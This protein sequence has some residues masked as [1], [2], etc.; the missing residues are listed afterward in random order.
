M[1]DTIANYTGNGT[2]TD[3]VVP[4]DYLKKSFVHVYV[5]N[6]LT[7]LTGGDYGDT[8]ADYYFLD[9]TTIRLK[10]AP[11]E[12][13][14]I[15]VRRYTS[16]TE[17]IVSFED[18]SI[19]KAT[20]LDTSQLQ[21][22]HIA[23]EAR[24]NVKDAML[25]DDEGNWDAQN[26]RIVNVADPV[27]DQDAMTLG[28]YKKDKQSVIDLK[29]ETKGY[30]DEALGFRNEAEEFKDTTKGYKD[31]TEESKNLAK[32]WAV[33]M[34]GKVVE[35]GEEIDYSA[36]YWAQ[37]VAEMGEAAKVVADNIDDVNTVA[38]N[39]DDINTV[40]GDL[41]GTFMPPQFTDMGR[42]GTGETEE[43]EVTG[44]NIKTVAD[45][46]ED[47]NSVASAIEDGSL[48][49]AIDSIPVTVENVRL[50]NEAKDDA[51]EASNKAKDW[52]IKIDGKVTDDAGLEVDYSSKYYANQAKAS[53]E[54][55]NVSADVVT[56][57]VTDGVSQINALSQQKVTEI[58]NAGT[59]QVNNVNT[60]GTAQVEAVNTAGSTQVSAVEDEG[61]SQV[62]AVTAEGTK[63]TGLVTAEG[64]KQITLVE[65]KGDS[66]IA[67]MDSSKDGLIAEI[68]TEG[69]T[70]LGLIE[71]AGTTQVGNINTAGTTQVS[72]VN[73]AGDTQVQAVNTAGTTQLAAIG[74]SAEEAIADIEPYVQK[75]H[76]WADK[77]DG[78]VEG[79]AYS[80]KYWANQAASGQLNA[81]WKETDSSN[82]GY[83][84]NKPDL[85]VYAEKTYVD[86]ALSS[87]LVYKGSVNTYADLPVASQKVGDMYNVAQADSSHGIK[88]GDNVAWNGSAWDVL[89][90]TV[91]L[92]AYLTKS[93]ASS[94]YATIDDLDA[95]NNSIDTLET[96]VGTK[97]NDSAV[98][99]LTG[100]Q[101]ITGTKTFS[102][103]IAGN[104]NGT[105]RNV[106]ERYTKTTRGDIEYGENNNYLIDKAALALWNGRYSGTSSNLEYC[107]YGTI[108]DTTRDQT[109]G[110]TKTFS[111]TIVGSINGNAATADKLKTARTINGTSFNGSA[112]ININNIVS[113]GQVTG[114]TGSTRGSVKG[115]QLYEAYNNGYPYSYGNVI[116]MRGTRNDY[117]GD[118]EIM[119][120]WNGTDRV[121]VRSLRDTASAEWT[122]WSELQIVRTDYGRV[123]S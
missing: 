47:V 92:S 4:F 31:D 29:N 53:A 6:R 100:N 113:R 87:A 76:D 55:A 35:E 14:G 112:N 3:F 108:I 118:N 2:Q 23:E 51:V 5:D 66:V 111:E 26:A 33:K 45:N 50:S 9:D 83:I 49:I 43:V 58:T 105:A 90:G 98:V 93:S 39:I 28:Y 80:A 73:D 96:T 27:D 110:G 91:D 11:A 72:N 101:T 65:Q 44:G 95:T 57:A 38:D 52:A 120:T 8:G 10:T 15:V 24:D 18:A 13:E 89:A 81:D 114:L 123:G 71:T 40:A 42:V 74:T 103:T 32:D 102:S 17:R 21:A 7:L 106:T 48:Q 116:H 121:F 36:K 64:T 94:T 119:F 86:S 75:A 97:A 12:G 85:S 122:E 37:S 34:N 82:K 19:L 117:G 30:R 60:A 99:K 68:Q 22:F 84:K 115:I 69:E 63:Q 62:S 20:D 56:E 25:R 104:I 41:E 46:I 78:P 88:A 54:K 107:R 77:T 61:A 1:A 16:A 67:T 70:Q 79:D 109:I 59:E